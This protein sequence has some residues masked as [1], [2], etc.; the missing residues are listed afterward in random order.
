MWNANVSYDDT[1]GFLTNKTQ[2]TG[3]IQSV[4]TYLNTYIQGTGSI[5]IQVSVSQTPSGRFAGSGANAVGGEF[6]EN[7]LIYMRPEAATEL[8]AGANLNGNSPDLTIFVDPSTDYYKG[9]FFDAGAYT[10]QNTVVP[11]LATD[12]QSV[13]L[14]EIIHGLG[15][16]SPRQ[17]NGQF[18]SNYRSMWDY[19]LKQSGN[20]EYLNVPAFAA[21]GLAPIQVTSDSTTQNHTHLG[22]NGNLAEG[23]LDDIMNGVGFYVGHRYYMSQIDLMILQGLGYKVSIPDDMPLSYY[24]LLGKG[25]TAP[26][27]TAGAGTNPSNVLHLTGTAM[28]GS[29]TSVLEHGSLLG[30][31][32]TDANGHWTLDV[33]VDPS[34][35]ASTL[36]VRDGTHAVDSGTIAVTRDTT[37]DN[38]IYGTAAYTKLVGGT[39]N[40]LFTTAA[41]GSSIDGAAGRD[42]VEYNEARSANTIVK[43]GNSFTITDAKGTDTLTNVERIQFSD[44][45]YA[46]DVGADGVAGQAYRLY[47]AAFNRAPD[48]SGLGF[49][50]KH[51]DSGLSL[52]QAAQFFLSSPEAQTLYGANPT[53]QQLVTAMYANVLHRA[54]DAD[55]FAFWTQ[56]LTAGLARADML[57]YFSESPEN[58]TALASIIGNG[59]TYVPA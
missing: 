1:S 28:A 38:H 31:T 36:V 14:H 54:P 7:G 35:T 44:S 51:M 23:Y 42:T 6:S 24:N 50:I 5:N 40:D 11:A 32:T 22:N 18:I 49:W 3:A 56:H 2:F 8:N 58:Q 45:M 52:N 34:L 10:D 30:T 53:D 19:Y 48:Q 27:L 13:L 55:G 21:A 37:A 15:I 33:T 12:G 46:L 4:I 16:A 20:L 9:L 43:Q 59:F 26:S 25:L 57:A 29:M 47:Q 39:H 17:L 41:R